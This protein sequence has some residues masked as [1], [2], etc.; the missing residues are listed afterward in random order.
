MVTHHVLTATDKCDEILRKFWEIEETMSDDGPMTVEEK[1][2]AQHFND[3]HFRDEFGTF[4][5]PLPRKQ[6]TKPL[7]ESR[8]IALRIFL[9]LERSLLAKQQSAEFNSVMSEYFE[10]NHAEVVPPLDVDKTPDKIFYLPMHAVRK[11]SSSTTKLRIVFDASAK[12]TSGVSLNDTLL[13]GHTVHSSLADVLLRF[14]LHKVALVSDVSKMYRAIKLADPD[15]DLHRFVWRNNPNEPLTDYRMTRVTF[16]VSAS[17]FAANMSLKQNAI[18]HA[19]EYPL[20]VKAVHESFYVDDCLTGAES[21]SEA[22][23]LQRQLQE[24]FSKGGFL[25]RKWCSSDPAVLKHLTPELKDA[26]P[27]HPI[28]DANEYT[29]TLGIQ[30]NSRMDHFR[31]TVADLPP[32]K[33]VTKR[34]LVSD[35][36]K[37]FDALGWFSPAV[38]KIKI[39]LQRVW[40]QKV[41]WDDTV[42][43]SIQEIWFR[44]RSELK[45][46]STKS[47]P[48]CYF[49]KDK[50]TNSRE[51]HGFCDASE[52]A[53]AAVVYFRTTDT[54]GGVHV[55]VVIAKTRVAP[56]KRLTIPRLELCGAHML[57]KLLDHLKSLFQIPL[58]DI[59]AW[60][61]STVVLN[62]LEGNPRRFKTYVGNRVSDIVACIPPS[63]WGHVKG[64]ENPADCGSRGLFP[65]KLLERDL[66]W[67]GPGWLH[68]DSS[69]WPKM[70]EPLQVP[71]LG[72]EVS[73][74]VTIILYPIIPLDRY[75]SFTKLKR[76]TAWIKRF[77][78]NCHSQ[79]PIRCSSLSADEM[80]GAE[81]YWLT[82]S[83]WD[84][85]ENEFNSLKSDRTINRASILVSFSPFVDKTGL[86]RV[87]GRQNLSRKPYDLIHP[88]IIHGKHPLTKMIIK[89]EHIRLSHAG[90]TLVQSSLSRRYHIVGGRKVI[91]CVIR[92]C[93]I[94]RKYA[95]KTA[96]QIMG[97]LPLERITPDRPFANVGV[98][99]AGP[100]YV[101]YVYVRKHTVV[102]AYACVFVSLSVKAAHLELVSDLTSSAF[103]ACLRRFVARR[104]KPSLIMSDNG[105]NFVG[106]NRELKEF[107][108]FLEDQKTHQAISEFCSNIHITWKFIP[109]RAPHFGGLWEAT[110]KSMKKHLK[111]VVGDHRLSFEEL[112][113]V[114][115][116]IEACLN[117]RPLTPLPNSEDCL[118]ALTPGHFLNWSF[119]GINTRSP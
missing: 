6:Y 82:L 57:T 83:Q 30:W 16:G 72:E 58:C 54:Y 62:W 48:R 28:P 73:V 40:E 34:S 10:L 56:I 113:T 96:N 52:S 38:I 66:W 26:P 59:Y 23:K 12:T 118:E 43:K 117:S 102:K 99:F 4:V 64:L 1:H 39:L 97:N 46:L 69:H 105:T 20:A 13:V 3:N 70:T 116:Q 87:G 92:Q 98:D 27:Q 106:A 2:V 18:D 11:D 74:H 79:S 95:A 104:G 9:H 108:Q 63:R 24:L 22:T 86:L 53:Y 51:L 100:F 31:L 17:S 71:D 75:S 119:F 21:I 103:I 78:D 90:T 47:I 32:V 61:D 77:I 80:S 5:V 112:S 14:R 25:L 101:K 109:E 81:G 88:I 45:L 65:S 44:W 15:K 67:N 33:N 114:L 8:S 19:R 94:C 85:F 36:A 7:G 42:P 93:V 84:H 91:R 76:V 60:S 111:R 49:P 55:S 50:F 29:K 68:E 107:C 115:T 35:I 110:V 41:D 89:S 37:T